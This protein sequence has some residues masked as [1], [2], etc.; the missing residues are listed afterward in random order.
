MIIH[1]DIEQGTPEWF[2]LRSGFVSASNADVIYTPTGKKATGQKVINY[3]NTLI[4]ERIMSAPADSGFSSAAMERGIILEAE[5]RTWYE[6]HCDIDVLEV[7]MIEYGDTS[8]S[9]DGLVIYDR[10]ANTIQKG[11]EIKCPL[12]H[13]Q[14]SYLLKGIV[15]NQY[16]PQLQA[17]MLVSGAIE[18]DFLSYHPDLSPL[19]ITVKRDDEWIAGFQDV[20]K[21]FIEQIKSGL[22]QLQATA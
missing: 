10:E 9:P 13:T 2:L 8:C 22:E 21:P 15:P 12:A 4:A 7:G 5:A 6:M 19:L 18:W 17:S 14:I 1:Y 11:L 3:A 16:I 20:L